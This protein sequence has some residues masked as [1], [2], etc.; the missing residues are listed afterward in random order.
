MTK[1]DPTKRVIDQLEHSATRV[2]QL[3]DALDLVE[4]DAALEGANLNYCVD[5]FDLRRYLQS[6]FGSENSEEVDDYVN[7]LFFQ[8]TRPIL[9]PVYYQEFKS[10]IWSHF[11]SFGIGGKSF[12]SWLREL[13]DSARKELKEQKLLAF[14]RRINEGGELD[15]DEF[16]E[17]IGSWTERVD[18]VL[19]GLDR[20]RVGEWMLMRFQKCF[21]EGQIRSLELP[22]ATLLRPREKRVH[23][24]TLAMLQRVRKRSQRQNQNDARAIELTHRLNQ[25][26]RGNGQMYC[27][28]SGVPLMEETVTRVNKQ[29]LAGADAK[30]QFRSPLYW[31]LWFSLR[32]NLGRVPQKDDVGRFRMRFAET[33]GNLKRESETLIDATQRQL[34]R[35][36]PV[37]QH[38]SEIE[39]LTVDLDSALREI[40]A[41]VLDEAWNLDRLEDSIRIVSNEPE[42][43]TTLTTLRNLLKRLNS[44]SAEERF[45]D[46]D[47]R[48][49]RI[50]TLFEELVQLVEAES[51]ATLQ[52]RDLDRRFGRIDVGGGLGLT[53]PFWEMIVS[54]DDQGIAKVEQVRHELSRMASLTIEQAVEARLVA[55]YAYLVEGRITECRA[56][57]EAARQVN[58]SNSSVAF[59]DAVTLR[60]EGRTRDADAVLRA[61]LAERDSCH[62]RLQL[63]RIA[64]ERFSQT[65][66]TEDLHTAFNESKVGFKIATDEPLS[67]QLQLLEVYV[68]S[69]LR[70]G[71]SKQSGWERDQKE[72]LRELLLEIESHSKLNVLRDRA[73][74]VLG[75]LDAQQAKDTRREL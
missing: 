33:L 58:A 45:E 43:E 48:L 42:V 31:R 72:K 34:F 21:D 53:E 12:Q 20:R 17:R 19:E 14:A 70:R 35:G 5:F 15:R 68:E 50:S 32:I 7:I 10:D 65:S 27:L 60:F 71:L 36:E 18:R 73:L 25:S 52:T 55:A 62:I 66:S 46:A 38:A 22:D 28:V 6:Q 4:N 63:A 30:V 51:T 75:L 2:R 40:S 9:L 26:Y 74:R 16:R 23:D 11:R 54:L 47:R 13:R 41:P 61:L 8:Q 3:L 29:L 56:E 24:E 67:T 49:Q 44:S 39:H 57:V 37:S 64:W 69:G 1:G 59:L